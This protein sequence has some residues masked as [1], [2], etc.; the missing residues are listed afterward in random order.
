MLLDV[1]PVIPL[2]ASDVDAWPTAFLF[3]AVYANAVLHH[4]GTQQL[5]D[6]VQKNWMSTFYPEKIKNRAQVGYKE[7]TEGSEKQAQER[8]QR[9]TSRN[10]S[11][12]LDI[13]LHLPYMSVPLEKRQ[14]MLKE[15]EEQAHAAERRSLEEKIDSW[16]KRTIS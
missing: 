15:A 10:T 1:A 9:H 13:L 8:Q 11:D 7:I 2:G 5:K 4:F 16:K 6:E 3:D 14:A 12:I